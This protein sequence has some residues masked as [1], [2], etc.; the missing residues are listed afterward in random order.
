M[1]AKKTVCWCAIFLALCI[2]ANCDISTN[3]I[4]QRKLLHP[5]TL[6]P[7]PDPY[8]LLDNLRKQVL[9]K[10][11]Q[12]IK[13]E[14]INKNFEKMIELVN[15]LGQVDSFLT[16]KTRTMIKKLAILTDADV[17]ID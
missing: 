5:Y 2:I 11:E 9:V 15:I 17:K 7:M 12:L 13:T 16:D 8:E 3:N 6:K 1:Y 4:I 10:E 14:Q